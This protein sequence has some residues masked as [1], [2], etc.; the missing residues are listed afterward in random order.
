MSSLKQQ[1]KLMNTLSGR[2]FPETYDP[3]NTW[4]ENSRLIQAKVNRGLA[5]DRDAKHEHQRWLQDILDR[6]AANGEVGFCRG[7]TE[8]KPQEEWQDWS[9][10]PG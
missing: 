10:A 2:P 5:E 6:K 9:S 7:E 4:K 1:E 3:Q 8:E